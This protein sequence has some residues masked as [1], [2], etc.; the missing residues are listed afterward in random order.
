[1]PN[2]IK[3]TAQAIA[4]SIEMQTLSTAGIVA[5]IENALSTERERCANLAERPET[6]KGRYGSASG[7]AENIAAA[8]RT[9]IKGELK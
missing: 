4:L 5:L 3:K 7:A 1:M 9:S 6:I 2:D 8:I